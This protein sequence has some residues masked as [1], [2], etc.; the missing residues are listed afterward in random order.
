MTRGR[1]T[2]AF[3]LRFEGYFAITTNT[4]QF[5]ANVEV[6][7]RAA[8]FVAEG[9]LGFD[10]LIRFSPFFFQFSF[11]ASIRLSYEGVTLAGVRISGT[12]SG[13]GPVT[14][15]G[16]LCFQ[17]LLIEICWRGTFEIGSPAQAPLRPVRA[18]DALAEELVRAGNLRDG[19]GGDPYVNLDTARV[20]ATRPV[21]APAGRL[22]WTQSRAP[23]GLLLQRFEGTPLQLEETVTLDGGPGATPELDWFA[24]GSFA[25]LSDSEALNRRSFE[26]LQGGVQIGFAGTTPSDA[27]TH[28]VMVKEHLLPSEGSRRVRGSPVAPWLLVAVDAR[29]GVGPDPVVVPLF[30]V[31]DER[32]EVRGGDGAV[33]VGTTSESQAHQLARVAAPGAAAVPVGDA[34]PS[35]GPVGGAE[36]RTQIRF[37]GWER[38]GVTALIA[39]QDEGRALARTSVRLVGRTAGGGLQSRGHDFEFL[40]TGPGDVVGLQPGAIARRYPHPGT[41]DAETTKCPYVEFAD[42]GLP[43]RYTPEPNPPPNQRRLPALARAA[44]RYGGR[45]AAPGRP[46]HRGRH[47]SREPLPRRLAHVG[48]SSGGGRSPAG[49]GALSPPAAARHQL[50]GRRRSRL[51]G[52]AGRHVE[53]RLDDPPPG[54]GRRAQSC[55]PSTTSGGSTPLGSAATSAPW[56]RR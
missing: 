12:L 33:V 54:A 43:W 51:L 55:S 32:W 46:G 14:F 15:T 49:P 52:C 6:V 29:S 18:F 9:F 53:R 35:A 13:P 27:L 4:L 45:D 24:P 26:R 34:I 10:V 17:I 25:T 20:R 2:D 8:G 36:C 3:Y 44:G 23:L 5:G 38:P 28:S 22:V 37:L 21:I 39:R 41:P 48:P 50:P 56:P 47:R 40:L 16:E 30:A 42:P 31:D 19:G 7:L 1:R 11:R